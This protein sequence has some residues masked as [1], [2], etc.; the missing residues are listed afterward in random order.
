MTGVNVGKSN[1]HRK[2]NGGGGGE[3]NPRPK[4]PSDETPDDKE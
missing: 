3:S 1:G 2:A 4:A